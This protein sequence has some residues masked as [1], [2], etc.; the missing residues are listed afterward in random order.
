MEIA[1]CISCGA[2]ISFREDPKMGQLVKCK[3]CNAELEVVWLDPVEL[4]WPFVDDDDDDE[5]DDDDYYYD[6]DDD[7]EDD[8]D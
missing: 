1:E 5:E 8:D 4:D 3:R 6:Y 2:E 7:D